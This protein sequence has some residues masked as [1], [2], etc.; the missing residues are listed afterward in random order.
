MQLTKLLSFVLLGAAAVSAQEQPATTNETTSL[1]NSSATIA[2]LITDPNNNL[3]IKRFASLLQ[4]DSGYQPIIDLLGNQTANYTCFVPNDRVMTKIMYLYK[5][6]ANSQKLNVT[7]DYPP[8]NFTIS[9]VSISDIIYYH[10]VNESMQLSNL[11]SYVN[12]VHSMLNNETIDRLGT[13]LPILIE[14][15]AT[16][17]EFNNKTWLQTH[18]K[19]LEYEVGNGN[20]DGD[21]S[22][23]DVEASNGYVNVIKSILVPP[24][25]PSQVIAHADDT[26][27]L[28]KILKNHPELAEELDNANNF[29]LFAPD[30]DAL[31]DFEFENMSNET[32]R[33]IVMAHIVPGVYY[34]TNLTE[35]AAANNGNT[36]LTTMNNIELPVSVNG[37]KITLN[38]TVEVEE[39]NIFF[40]SGVMYVIDKVLDYPPKQATA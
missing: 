33:S 31:E 19:Y 35:Q 30:D 18:G 40:N 4:S 25:K 36:N 24:T 16:Y 32:I 13:G 17:H 8:A 29:T 21:V 11:T 3:G 23:K 38:N 7:G 15:N 26:E 10:I 14:N 2:E 22:F 12:I 39:A 1:G 9:N 20:D 28:A 27:I 6:Y 34:S 5:A 37:S